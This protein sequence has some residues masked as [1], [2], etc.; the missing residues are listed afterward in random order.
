MGINRSKTV[1]VGKCEILEWWRQN[2]QLA[3]YER[4]RNRDARN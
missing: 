3:C 2:E 1:V 4:K